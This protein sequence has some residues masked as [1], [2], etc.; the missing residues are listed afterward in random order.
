MRVDVEESGRIGLHLVHDVAIVSRILVRGV[1]LQNPLP[2][3]AS[4][5]DAGGV[6]SKIKHRR[7]IILVS[8]L[9][10]ERAEAG[11]AWST[12]VLCFHGD[13]EVRHAW[14]GFAVESVSCPDDASDW[15]NVELVIAVVAGSNQGVCDV[16]IGASV[17]VNGRYL[18]QGCDN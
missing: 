14:L 16:A 10:L 1:H 12:L 11:Q 9:H 8:D 7:V 17:I 2:D 3:N 6:L 18:Y 5:L 4:L 15:L 13:A